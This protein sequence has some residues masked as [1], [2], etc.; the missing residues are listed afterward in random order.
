[1][2]LQ[3]TLGSFI[4]G[5][6][7]V[8]VHG[9]FDSWGPGVALTAS[10]GD[11]DI[12]QA[13]VEVGGAAGAA[14]QHKFVINQA[15]TLVW[16]NNG[17]GPDGAQNRSFTLPDAAQTLPVVYFNNQSSPP[18][19]TRVTFQ[20]DMGIQ[21][22]M[23][24]FDSTNDLVEVHGSFDSWGPGI[25]LEVASTNANIYVGTV[26][27]TGSPGT[28]YEHKFLINKAGTQT[29]EGNVGAGGGFGNR[30]FTL[31][32][33]EQSLPLVY[34]DNLSIDPGSGVPVTFR[35]NMTVQAALGLFDPASG[36]MNLAGQFNNWSTTETPLTNSAA[37]PNIYTGTV[38]IKAATG[39]SVPFKFVANG[40]TWEAID[41]RT[42]ALESPSQTLPVLWFNN[43]A[44][45]GSLAITQSAP[46]EIAVS[47]TA[48]PNLRLQ[49]AASLSGPWQD[50]PETTGA[51]SASFSA[52]TTNLFFRLV[53]P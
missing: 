46:S 41:N 6:H 22:S 19:T 49:S 47:W 15:G 25:P 5:S 1:M 21:K 24:R 48:G 31:E 10:A 44:N 38:Q 3:A 4:P 8:E 29:W 52:G 43:Q 32:A 45:L 11:A 37:E 18:G 17:V 34:F 27:I 35:V 40:G 16:E 33:G 2:G 30:T 51:E 42:F 9:S 14:I 39:S 23:G 13:T 12:Y 7:T 50:L 28:S 26:E 53:G 36:T 20:I